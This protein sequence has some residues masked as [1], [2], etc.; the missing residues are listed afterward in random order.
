MVRKIIQLR[1]QRPSDI[2][3]YWSLFLQ[4]TFQKL[5]EWYKTVT[6]GDQVSNVC[7]RECLF[8]KQQTYQIFCVCQFQIL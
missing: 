6:V 5:D 8:R 1:S 7:Q 2:K 4:F 3:E